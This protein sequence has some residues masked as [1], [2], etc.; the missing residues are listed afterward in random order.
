[1]NESNLEMRLANCSSRMLEQLEIIREYLKEQHIIDI[2]KL[3]EISGN[4]HQLNIDENIIQCENTKRAI[5]ELIK[6][7]N[8]ERRRRVVTI[9]LNDATTAREKKTNIKN[10]S[11]M[12]R[13]RQLNPYGLRSIEKDHMD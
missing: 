11:R 9:S 5:D 12:M 8:L 6:L 7:L 4:V 2:N 1:M 3:I 13:R 10:H